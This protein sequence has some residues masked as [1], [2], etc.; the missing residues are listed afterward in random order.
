MF[1]PKLC[2]FMRLFLLALA[3]SASALLSSCASVGAAGVPS[4]PSAPTAPSAPSMSASAPSTPASAALSAASSA[5]APRAT[6]SVPVAASSAPAL[7]APR[8]FAE[9]IKDA[10]R[11]EGLFGVWTKDEKVWLEIAPDQFEKLYFFQV[12]LNQGLS[13]NSFQRGACT[14]GKL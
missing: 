13:S 14:V 12:N 4:V 3:C 8:P 2:S 7:G 1:R 11:K 6:A 10:T 9:V 5:S